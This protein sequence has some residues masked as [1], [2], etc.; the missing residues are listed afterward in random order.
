MAGVQAG[1]YVVEVLAPGFA[2]S[3]SAPVSV[4]QGQVPPPSNIRLTRGGTISGRIVDA[5]GKPVA[6]ARI[7]THDKD[8][9]D[10]EF[11]K[12]LGDSYPSDVTEVDVRSGGDGRFLL[13]GMRPETYQVMIRAPGYTRWVRNDIFVT[14]GQTTDLGDIKLA[15]GGQVRGTLLDAAGA[16]LVGGMVHLVADD[17]REGI[18]YSTKSGA[19]GKFLFMNV[20][21]GQYVISGARTIGPEDTPFDRFQDTRNS[22]KSISV[23]DGS[24]NTV[25]LNLAP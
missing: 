8:W 9:M 5:A 7:T 13:K 22:Q 1:S 14:E 12:L 25:E 17:G 20:S 24:T 21:P 10:D 15:A 3:F 19:D 4:V 6:R 16:P 11:N 18:G 2:P 23:V